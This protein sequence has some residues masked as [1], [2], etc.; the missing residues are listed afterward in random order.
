MEDEAADGDDDDGPKPP[1]P[2][3]ENSGDLYARFVEIHHI[4]QSGQLPG[5]GCPEGAR[6][7]SPEEPAFSTV[8]ITIDTCEYRTE[9][10]LKKEREEIKS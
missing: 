4:P 2:I 3:P 8:G 5:D 9:E 6:S 1:L 10:M 7:P